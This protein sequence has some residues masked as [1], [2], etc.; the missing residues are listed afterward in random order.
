MT[1]DTPTDG[2]DG[3]IVITD[4]ELFDQAIAPTPP[5]QPPQEP[6]QEHPQE[7]APPP[8]LGEQTAA[9]QAQRVRD[10]QGRFVKGPPQQQPPQMAPPA[11]GEPQ[12]ETHRVPLRELL[13]ERERRQRLETEMGQM[14]QAWEYFI[15]QQQRQQQQP[16]QPQTIFDAPDQYLAA[17]VVNPLRQEGERAMMQIKD[18][19]SR[20]MANQQF[21]DK[22]V[23]TALAELTK[24][25]YTPDGDHLFR[26]IMSAGHPYGVLVKWHQQAQA[27]QAIGNDPNAWLRQRQQEWVRDPNAQ[28]AVLDYI[29]SQQQ[30]QRGNGQPSNIQLPPS[31]STVPAASGR[32]G[33]VGDLTDASLWRFATR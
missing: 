6:S 16:Q 15:S 21:G 10:G 20:E 24:I 11:K 19:L 3:D 2:G 28:R 9:A 33:D 32:E 4:R 29:R 30:Q 12:M 26:Q 14:R 18:G 8:T 13:D 25:R 22:A 31:L 7:P 5:S 1:P 17:N 23:N 27:H